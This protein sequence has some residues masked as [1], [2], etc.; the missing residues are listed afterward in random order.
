MKLSFLSKGVTVAVAALTMAFTSDSQARENKITI[1]RDLDRDG[2]FNRKTFEVPRGRYYGGSHYYGHRYYGRPYYGSYYGG[3]GY[4]YYYGP[5]VGF[6]YYSSPSYVYST[7]PGYDDA[8]AADV[9]RE[10]RRRGYYHGVIDGDIGPGSR[11][12]IRAYQANHGLAVTGRIDGGLI[13]ALGV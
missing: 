7:A 8:L 6:S 12:A 5:R 2:H 3:F 4:P 10:L 11:A 1:R 13:R 9:Q